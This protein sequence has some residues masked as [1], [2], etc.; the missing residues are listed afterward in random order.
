MNVEDKK[1]LIQ[2]ST[3]LA[4]Y[5]SGAN[6]DEAA[7]LVE[8]VEEPEVENE[9]L[10]KTSFM[11]EVIQ[12]RKELAK[13][14]AELLL[15]RTAIKENKVKCL[16]CGGAGNRYVEDS[17]FGSVEVCPFC[18]GKKY[19]SGTGEL[20]AELT[21]L[22]ELALGDGVRERVLKRCKSC[23]TSDCLRCHDT[24]IYDFQQAIRDALEKK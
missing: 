10:Q 4:R 14:K 13:V 17:M 11:V 24:A 5:L 1:R 8:K 23:C 22:R 12:L 6:A 19:V 16:E 2:I 18:Y 7:W 20:E 21:R 9:M 3:R 15:A